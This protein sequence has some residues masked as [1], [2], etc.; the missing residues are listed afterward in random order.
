A[1]LDGGGFRVDLADGRSP[2]AR[3]LLV[4]T[5][6]ADELPDLPGLAER[7]GRDVLHCPYCHGWEVRDQAVGVLNTGPAATH[8][9][10]LFRQL[11]EDV[12][13]FLHTAD[14]P[15]A[16]ELEALTA[17]GIAL[18]DGAVAAVESAD[19]RL[20]GVRLES[21]ATVPLDALVVATRMAA[22]PGPLTALGLEPADLSMG[23][24]V[25]G[26][27]FA[28]A[29]DGATEVSGVW[30]AGNVADPKAQL[31]TAAAAGLAAGAAINAALVAEEIDRAVKVARRG[32][33]VYDEA[34]WEERYRTAD[35]VWSGDA[36]RQL[37]TE[38]AGL[39]PGT[40][41]DVGCGEGGDA[42]WLA[43]RGWRVHGVDISA[44]ALTRAA[45]HAADLGLADRT[46][47]A[48][49]DVFDWTPDGV[50]DLVTAQFMH[51]PEEH[52]TPLFA[53][54]ADA[55]APGGSLVLVG[56]HPRDLEN[57]D[58]HGARRDMLFT[59]EELAENLDPAVWEFTTVETRERKGLEHEGTD[60]VKYDAVLRARRRP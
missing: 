29:A 21:G 6:L 45:A 40:A 43:G 12:T 60:V 17:R 42:L 3:R 7:W 53:R 24:H 47:W 5:G 14:R 55:V 33:W 51:L 27:H 15:S 50:Y 36:N 41:L 44:T 49:A 25:I 19:D 8:Q 48:R 39:A 34:F 16:Q 1:A 23:G 30:I 11:T 37:V 46:S 57:D 26:S 31:I 22:R 20:T 9:A 54:L 32:G 59:P 35:R 4:T 10:Q 2:H 28:A 58:H 18:V 13:L 56:H 52:R 38:T